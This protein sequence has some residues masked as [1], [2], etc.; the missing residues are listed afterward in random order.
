MEGSLPFLAFHVPQSSVHPPQFGLVNLNPHSCALTT[1]G[2]S[3]PYRK[4]GRDGLFQ[5]PGVDSIAVYD[6]NLASTSTDGVVSRQVGM[7]AF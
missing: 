7:G 1:I 3:D 6:A 4:D 5:D 2:S